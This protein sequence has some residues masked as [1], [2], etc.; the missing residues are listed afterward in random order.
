MLSDFGGHYDLATFDIAPM[1]KAIRSHCDVGSR[2]I[3]HDGVSAP[4]FGVRKAKA[5]FDAENDWHRHQ[6]AEGKRDV[7][8]N[9]VLM[10]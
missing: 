10:R 7:H 3:F 2:R 5:E 4:L 9:L 1:R 6:K 8:A